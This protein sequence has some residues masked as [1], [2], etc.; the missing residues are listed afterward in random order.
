MRTRRPRY[1]KYT[2]SFQIPRTLTPAEKV[3][4]RHPELPWPI[5]ASIVKKVLRNIA[6]ADIASADIAG[7]TI[8]GA[9]IT[10][11]DIAGATIAGAT[12]TGATITGADI[13]SEEEGRS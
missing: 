11:A 6:S 1:S 8:T 4:L 13:A 9:T 12:I 3:R 7:A 2:R 10:G 5:T